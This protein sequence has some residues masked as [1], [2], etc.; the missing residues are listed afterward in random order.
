[1]RK[2]AYLCGGIIALSFLWTGTAFISVAYHLM[3]FFTPSQIDI[4]MS[5]T[6][7]LLQALGIAIM[8]IGSHLR[9]DLFLKKHFFSKIM[10]LEAIIITAALLSGNASM[11]LI[12]SFIMNLLHGMV[13]GCYLT[14]IAALVPQQFLGRVFGFGYAIGSVGSWLLSLPNG[15][16]FLGSQGMIFVYLVLIVLTL[17]L[18]SKSDDFQPGAQDFVG[19]SGFS[20]NLLI[21]AFGFVALL[22]LVKNIGFYF[23]V[24][25]FVGMISLEYSRI[26]YSLGLVAAGIINDISRKYGAICCLAALVFP[27]ISLV[28]LESVG[29]AA[30]MWIMGYIF[31]GFFS[32]F[33]VVVF[34]DISASKSSL[35]SFAAVGLLAGRIGDALGT[36]AGINLLGNTVLL[37]TIT[38]ILFIA[39]VFLF[40]S[41]YQKLYIPT[42]HLECN[43]ED[44]LKHFE[45]KYNLT[46]R[47][48]E[49]F[50][51]VLQGNS[52][53]EIMGMLYVSES[54]VKFHIGNILKKTGCTNRS[55]LT[56]L[57]ENQ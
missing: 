11:V 15:G 31:F 45:K 22:S 37:L 43:R 33:R 14:M 54:T 6:G 27:F 36:L 30:V 57:F 4:H 48:S 7:Y 29:Y 10:I 50:R 52:N 3:V 19:G 25:D 56:M 5:V 12:M 34:L 44:L 18:N 9:P 49:V 46:K 21:L 53:S 39:V 47:E 35:L 2:R 20:S 55:E 38:S 1:M 28:L 41:I 42:M 40:F 51:L 32:V 16:S 26:Y 24:A 17:L 23:P 13:A 8:V